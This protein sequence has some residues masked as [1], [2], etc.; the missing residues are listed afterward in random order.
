MVTPDNDI[1]FNRS[2]TYDKQSNTV[3]CLSGF[4]LKKSLYSVD[5]YNILQQ[6]Y[7]KMFDFLK[8]PLVLKKK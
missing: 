2:V 3:L 1:E 8:E 7:K 6:V 4:D 5:E